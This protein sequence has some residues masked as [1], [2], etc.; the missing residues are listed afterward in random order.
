MSGCLAKSVGFIGTGKMATAI[1]KGLIATGYAPSKIFTSD[2]S[3]KQR[4]LAGA[5]NVNVM[6]SNCDVARESDAVVVAV[7]PHDFS[8]VLNEIKD[9]VGA[10]KPVISIAGGLKLDTLE[11]DLCP[12]ARVLRVMPNV[13]AEVGESVSAI[14]GGANAS[15][16]DLEST[17]SIFDC[18]GI[19]LPIKE[20][21]FDAF[22]AVAGCG[23]AFIFPVIEALADG[24]VHEGLSRETAITLAAQMVLGSAKLVLKSR[25]HP[26]QLKD[27]VCSP[28][29]STIVG[30]KV[31]EENK[32]RSGFMNA[33][34]AASQKSQEMGKH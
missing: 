24:G 2:V 14:A 1:I 10:S 11:R 5:L 6:S 30:V 7:K 19:T 28:G 15:A 13:C 27:S 4:E 29:G 23:P 21:L 9:V 32:T 8:H 17:K 22:S 3:A 18:V 31:L 20:A 16:A 12:G 34:I 26:G 25:Q 33:V